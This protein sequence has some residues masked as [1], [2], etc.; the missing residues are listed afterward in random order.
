MLCI[1]TSSWF[2]FPLV[3]CFSEFSYISLA[4]W[5]CSNVFVPFLFMYI[6][7]VCV[8]Y[9]F[10]SSKYHSCITYFALCSSNQ[11]SVANGAVNSFNIKIK[12]VFIFVHNTLT[13]TNMDKKSYQLIAI[14]FKMFA[15]VAVKCCNVIHFF[16]VNTLF[17][18]TNFPKLFDILFFFINFFSLSILFTNGFACNFIS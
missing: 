15:W 14:A 6:C 5:T 2:L 18:L 3:W 4:Q 13:L 17:H 8:C 11:S 12:F 16:F 10:I 9:Y 7:F 1:Y